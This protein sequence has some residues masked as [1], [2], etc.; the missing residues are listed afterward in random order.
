MGLATST[1][2]YLYGTVSFVASSTQ[3]FQYFTTLLREK[4]AV[5]NVE[6]YWKLWV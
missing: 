3:A 4:F 6:N 2:L 1:V 5:A